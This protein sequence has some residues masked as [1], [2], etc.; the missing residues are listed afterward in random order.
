M[1]RPLLIA[2]AHEVF[3]ELELFSQNNSR[4]LPNEEKHK[5]NSRMHEN[6]IFAQLRH[7]YNF[8]K[9]L[10]LDFDLQVSKSAQILAATSMTSGAWCTHEVTW[11]FVYTLSDLHIYGSV[12]VTNDDESQAIAFITSITKV[13]RETCVCLEEKYQQNRVYNC[14]PRFLWYSL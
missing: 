7:C 10:P 12:E 13:S 4:E 11:D 2:H 14:W 1:G 9:P 5:R 6:R 8:F 3:V